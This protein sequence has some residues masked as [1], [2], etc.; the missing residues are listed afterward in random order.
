MAFISIAEAAELTGKSIP[1]LYQHI[2]EG[3]ISLSNDKV[4]AAELSKL[5]GALRTS[6]DYRRE[7]EFLHNLTLHLKKDKERLYQINDL[8]RKSNADLKQE[9]DKLYRIMS[10]EKWPSPRPRQIDIKIKDLDHPIKIEKNQEIDSESLIQR[11]F[12]KLLCK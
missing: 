4:N 10:Q 2:L 6:A 1:T 12:R 3:K 11:L 8:L 5:Y 9:K 7:N